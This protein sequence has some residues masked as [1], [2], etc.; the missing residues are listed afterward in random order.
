MYNIWQCWFVGFVIVCNDPVGVADVIVG[1]VVVETA[2]V[3]ICVELINSDVV[4]NESPPIS[5]TSDNN[6]S[7]DFVGVKPGGGST[8]S[9]I[10][11]ARWIRAVSS[12]S[13]MG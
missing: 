3:A 5:L 1:D 11:N 12:Q 6:G 13:S 9:A 4:G 2:S 7:V 8:P 10:S